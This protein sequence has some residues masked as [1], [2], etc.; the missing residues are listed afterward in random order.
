M[1]AAIFMI[2]DGDIPSCNIT[3]IEELDKIGRSLDGAGSAAAGYVL[4]GGQMPE[5]KYL[6]T[7]DLFSSIPTLD[8]CRTVTQEILRGMK[9]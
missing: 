1:A 4:R 9:R 3:I 6:C 5:S 8:D 7:F 2:R